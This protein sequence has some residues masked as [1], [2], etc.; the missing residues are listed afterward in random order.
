MFRQANFTTS[1][2]E[3]HPELMKYTDKRRKDEFAVA[4]AV[5]AG[6]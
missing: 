4:I 3:D 2:V 1:F 5:H 6:L